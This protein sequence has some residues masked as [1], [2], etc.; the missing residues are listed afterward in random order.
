RPQ[1]AR[2]RRDR[3]RARAAGGDRQVAALPRA[4]RGGPQDP[5]APRET[6][7]RKRVRVARHG[8][9]GA[10]MSCRELERLWDAGASLPETRA[11]QAGCPECGRA[12]DV[13]AQTVSALHSLK[14]PAWSPMLRQALL[15]IPRR[16][17]S[18]EGAEPLLALALEG[19]GS[20]SAAD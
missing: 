2:L 4:R 9:R 17:V 14:A 10:R 11:H 12:G 19:D 7:G 13:L 6:D 15:D 18:C 20:L 1:R 16:T 3:D 5:R 8:R